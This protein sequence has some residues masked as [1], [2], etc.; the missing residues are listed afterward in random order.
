MKKHHDKQVLDESRGTHVKHEVRPQDSKAKSETKNSFVLQTITA[1]DLAAKCFPPIAYV[2]PNY[3][4]QGLT[5]LAGRPKAGKSWLALSI[6]VGVAMGCRVLGS[7]KVEQGDVLYLAL[8][9]NQRRLQNRLN[10]LL[11]SPK[12]ERL[13]LA[14]EC[15]RLDAG[16]LDAI[17]AWCV[18]VPKAR[19]I[20]IDVLGKIR[21]ERGPSESLYDADYRSIEPLKSLADTHEIAVI[22]VHHTNKREELSDPFDAVSGTTGLTGAA[23]TVLILARDGLGITLYGRGRDIAEIEVALQFDSQ[24]G[25][26]ALLGDADVVR[27]TDERK[28]ILDALLDAD[29]PLG[30]AAIADSAEMKSNNV[31]RLVG[32]MVKAGEVVKMGRGKYRHPSRPDLDPGNDHH[33]D[34]EGGPGHVDHKVTKVVN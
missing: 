7:I 32:K 33:T 24:T 27:R 18:R 25:H 31:R 21:S 23:D 17:E 28:A 2:V 22:V 19:L 8:E 12:P 1:S 30:P 29:E 11:P 10:K 15:P 4:A 26:W 16:G 13:H 34:L 6:A 9:D 5:V 20:V 3:I 14:T